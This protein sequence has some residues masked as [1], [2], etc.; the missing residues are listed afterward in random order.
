MKYASTIYSGSMITP[1]QF[2]I[3]L[4]LSS[5]H[6]LSTIT[7]FLSSC[8]I[9]QR[10]LIIISSGISRNMQWEENHIHLKCKAAQRKT[11]LTSASITKMMMKFMHFIDKGNSSTFLWRWRRR[12]KR[13]RKNIRLTKF[14]QIAKSVEQ[15]LHREIKS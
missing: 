12:H 10:W 15:V 6:A 7:L 8:A 2:Q 13:K 9:V 3:S 1:C 14:A 11:F 5:L 4:I